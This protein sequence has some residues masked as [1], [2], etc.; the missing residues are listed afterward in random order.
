MSVIN[1]LYQHDDNYAIYGGVSLV[2]LLENNKSAE[3]INVFFCD[4]G[5]SEKYKKQYEE[6]IKKYKRNIFFISAKPIVDKFSC[7]GFPKYRGSYAT[8]MKLFLI[9]LL[10]PEVERIF[11]IDSDTLILGQ[12]DN[13]FE[14][15]YSEKPIYM[16][17]DAIASL[18]KNTFGFKTDEP[19]Y[20]GG[21]MLF[22]VKLWKKNNCINRLFDYAL[23]QRSSYYDADQGLLNRVLFH[24]IGTLPLEYDYTYFNSIYSDRLVRKVLSKSTYYSLEEMKKARNNIVVLDFMRFLGESPWH[25]K[26]L[27]PHKN[28]FYFYLKLSPWYENFIPE[29]PSRRPFFLIERLLYLILPKSFF[30]F[31]F[32]SFEKI[33]VKKCDNTL[34]RNNPKNISF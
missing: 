13:L 3:N 1:V 14:L 31:I 23:N 19:Y 32:S 2:S 6:I 22:N 18:F 29:K 33:Y 11:Y 8:Y 16:C 17:I 12:L 10:P 30:L 4:S 24:E 34:K 9:D 26:T 25:K 20:C 15:N 27:H 21:T 7:V 28:Y 5:L